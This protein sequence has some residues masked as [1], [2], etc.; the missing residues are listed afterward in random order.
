MLIRRI[1]VK[2]AGKYLNLLTRLDRE[3]KFMMY[4]PGE[5]KT[6]G[7]EM[8]ERIK[9]LLDSGSI[10]FVAQQDEELVGFICA[11]RG[12]AGRIRHSA[13]IFT[14]ILQEHTGKGIGK[15]LF[16][17][18]D[19]W[20]AEN[21]V[22]RLELT[23]MTHNERALGLYKKSGYVVEGVKKRSLIIDGRYVDEYYMGKLL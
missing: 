23:V 22:T 13:Y 2:D 20:A 16:R 6:T 10:V 11:E 17:Q 18:V 8:E 1:E 19:G 12:F 3:T 9:G 14:G 7:Q 15:E 21:G 4:E 5:R